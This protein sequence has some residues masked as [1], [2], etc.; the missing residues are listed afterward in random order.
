MWL[1][2]ASATRPDQGLVVLDART[3]R[4][5][6]FA[7]LRRN[8][9]TVGVAAS[10]ARDLGAQ[11]ARDG[12]P[13]V[14]TQVDPVKVEV[15]REVEFPVPGPA[16]FTDVPPIAA[17]PGFAWIAVG[18][19][20][21]RVDGETGAIAP[22]AL[23]GAAREGIAADAHS[24][25]LWST[26]KDSQVV[27]FDL[28]TNTVV[29]TLTTGD[30]GFTH[31][32]AVDDQA[33]WV[34]AVYAAPA[35]ATGLRLSRID[36]MT[37]EVTTFPIPAIEV[38]AGDGQVWVQLYD[39]S[40]GVLTKNGLVAQVDPATGELLRTI[41]TELTAPASNGRALSVG[42][43]HIWRGPT[44][45][46]PLSMTT[47]TRGTLRSSR[48]DRLSKPIRRVP[49]RSA[50]G[51]A[52]QR[53][54]PRNRPANRHVH[55]RLLRPTIPVPAPQPGGD[56]TDTYHVENGEVVIEYCLRDT[57]ANCSPT[58]DSATKMDGATGFDVRGQ[59]VLAASFSTGSKTEAPAL[60][61]VSTKGYA[62]GPASRC[63]TKMT[64]LLR[65][66][67]LLGERLTQSAGLPSSCG[68]FRAAPRRGCTRSRLAGLMNLAP[69]FRRV[70]IGLA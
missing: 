4:R 9:A 19:T 63:E 53:A 57:S 27:R 17:T 64:T 58:L 51:H 49:P 42:G 23:P 16:G 1:R 34:T 55:W 3:L 33:A 24:L 12:S 68:A 70:G 26:Q 20:L 6:G 35:G 31:S 37:Y 66:A 2:G 11:P 25:W 62:T 47:L 40:N 29:R 39:K 52:L 59:L 21:Y 30:P 7:A 5:K 56:R 65:R 46:T 69:C 44:R 13:Y 22:F 38:V 41:R 14:V 67:D 50:R 18:R 43:G 32:L 8:Y 61:A 28:A 36:A 10:T 15:H 45:I 54:R 60:A 48:A